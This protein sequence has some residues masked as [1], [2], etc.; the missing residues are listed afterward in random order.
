[1]TDCRGSDGDIHGLGK[2]VPDT[3][4]TIIQPS[5]YHP[6]LLIRLKIVNGAKPLSKEL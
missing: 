5:G 2:R 6:S 4:E 1:M 3:N